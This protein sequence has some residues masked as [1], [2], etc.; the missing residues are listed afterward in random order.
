MKT[1]N[2]TP[3]CNLYSSASK[4]NIYVTK[5]RYKA[6]LNAGCIV[7]SIV[8]LLL[9]F[10][11]AYHLALV[12]ASITFLLLSVLLVKQS[13]EHIILSRFEL[14]SQGLCTFD[15][16]KYYQMQVDSRYSFLGCWLI[17]QPVTAVSTMANTSNDNS[18]KVCF[19]YRDSL[20]NQ[21]FSRLS[22]VISQLNYQ[23]HSQ[24]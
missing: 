17:L 11:Y 22:N 6:L 15:G 13:P 24:S 18:K 19:I 2:L 16:N 9:F 12:V 8:L 14:D 4:Y 3:W 20:S 10:T 23:V 1:A 7:T 5:S 21:D